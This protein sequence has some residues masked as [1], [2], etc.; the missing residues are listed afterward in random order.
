MD[1]SVFNRFNDARILVVGDIMLDRYI[2]GDSQ[3]ISPEAPVPIVKINKQENKLG[4][5]ANVAH[6][7]RYLDAQVGLLGVIGNDEN[8]EHVTHLLASEGIAAH[9]ITCAKPTITKVR[10]LSRKQQIVRL[11]FEVPFE[12]NETLTLKDQL[13]Q[14]L[15]HY[16][17]VV[18]SDYN[19][20][21]LNQVSDLI[22]CAKQAGKTVLVDPKKLDYCV[23]SGADLITPNL[24]EFL[25]AGGQGE[26]E[27]TIFDSARKLLT[28]C[29]INTMLL[30]RSEQGMSVITPKTKTDL[31]AHV[32]EVSDVTGAGD[33]VIA[34][35]AVML[36]LKQSYEAAAQIANLA[37]TANE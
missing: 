19:K 27:Q 11:D 7:I 1:I 26:S 17:L 2:M 22:H 33:T 34:T 37:A 4:G 28:Q 6:N 23:Y 25:L 20:G 12:H 9:L 8:G 14:L 21:T 5:A 3:R 36:A 18:F 29:R 32:R 13:T 31:N 30:T 24:S 10:V 15:P 16:D 35:M